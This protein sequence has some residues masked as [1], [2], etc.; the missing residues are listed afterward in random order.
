KTI[1]AAAHGLF[2]DGA[3][4]L[5]G[6]DGPDLILVCDGVG[7]PEV[8]EPERLRVVP[9]APLFAEAIA[10]LNGGGDFYDLLPYD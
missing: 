10:R 8:P 1:A 5:F 9:A 2:S 7:V 6:K 4:A 3:P